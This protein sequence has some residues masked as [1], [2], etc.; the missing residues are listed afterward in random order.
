[1]KNRLRIIW[2]I[3]KIANSVE[4]EDTSCN[5]NEYNSADNILMEIGAVKLSTADE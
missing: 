5:N 4:S 1:M 3:C 2:E